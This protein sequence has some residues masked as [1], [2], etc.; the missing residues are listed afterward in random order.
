MFVIFYIS[1]ICNNLNFQNQIFY[2]L[3]QL[4]NNKLPSL[5]QYKYKNKNICISPLSIYQIISLVSN[6][7]NGQTQKEI[8]Q[9]LTQKNDQKTQINLNSNN[10][11]ILKIYDNNLKISIANAIMSKVPISQKFGLISQRYKIF[12]S[13]LKNVEQVNKWCEEN[14]NGKIKK[15]IDNINGVDLILLNAVYFNY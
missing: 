10:I 12:Y 2:N 9:V 5:T 1:I 3:Q 11:N 14:T 15:I 8:L 4:T 6:G 13:F 7:A